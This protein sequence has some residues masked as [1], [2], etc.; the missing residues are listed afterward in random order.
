M[1]ADGTQIK[2]DIDTNLANKGYRGIRVFNII[3]ALKALVDW[4]TGVVNGNQSTWLRTSDNQPGGTT[5]D[6]VYRTGRVEFRGG[7]I[8][9]S[10]SATNRALALTDINAEFGL[11]VMGN[12]GGPAIMEFHLP[13]FLVHQIGLDTDGILKLRPW[14]S[15]ISHEIVASGYNTKISTNNAVDAKKLV[16][17]D[18]TGNAH[19]FVGLGIGGALR[20]QVEGTGTDHVFFAATS[21]VTSNELMRIKGN[22]SVGVGQSSPVA[23]IDILRAVG[24]PGFKLQTTGDLNK[25]TWLGF[26]DEKNYLRSTTILADTVSTD[27]VGIGLTTP[28]SKL[29]VKGATG[30][31]QLRLETPYTPA[32]TVDANG[33]AGQIAW[34]DT[35]F[36]VKTSAGWKRTALTTF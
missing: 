14:T 35:Y 13:G 18:V 2:Q 8:A 33:L 30:H 23:K 22:G 12:N 25:D 29:H 36:Y 9:K 34:S 17:Y 28:T 24:Q 11:Q 27:S 21:P 6:G 5:A 32:N 1:A 31:Q 20:Y 16:L 7:A 15:G 10:T 3:T 19:Q 4:V 26:T